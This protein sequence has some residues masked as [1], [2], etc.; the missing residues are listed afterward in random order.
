MFEVLLKDLATRGH[1]VYVVGHFP[2]KNPIP[3][4]TDNSVE[5]AEPAVVNNFTVEFVRGLGYVQVL[6]Y[7]W[8]T[9]LEI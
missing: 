6:N 8:N 4:Y 5:G 1:Q 7:M 9:N 3:S 2:Q